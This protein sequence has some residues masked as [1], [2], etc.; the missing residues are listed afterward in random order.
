MSELS[1][2]DNKNVAPDIAEKAKE[3]LSAALHQN[4]REDI[5]KGF[6]D[7]GESPD[8]PRLRVSKDK[9][10]AQ[11]LEW[12]KEQEEKGVVF[13]IDPESDKRLVNTNVPYE[14]LSPSWQGANSGAAEFVVDALVEGTEHGEDIADEEF[15]QKLA[16]MI[17][18][19]WME[20]NA[21]DRENNPQL[22]VPYEELEPKEQKKDADQVRIALAALGY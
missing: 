19:K 17:H 16:S 5:Q 22:F 8:T 9:T 18:D 1:R 4:W 10:E 14:E 7:K 6:L 20:D 12:Y 11:D 15:I 2:T 3:V 13:D 21:W